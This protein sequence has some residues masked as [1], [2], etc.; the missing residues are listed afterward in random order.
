M[1]PRSGSKLDVIKNNYY[2]PLN[3]CGSFF[4]G[5]DCNQDLKK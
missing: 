1:E 3:G 5:G 2:Q 4:H